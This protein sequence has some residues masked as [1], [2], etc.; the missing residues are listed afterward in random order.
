MLGHLEGT[1]VVVMSAKPSRLSF[2]LPAVEQACA[3]LLKEKAKEG[4]HFS[5]EFQSQHSC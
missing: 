3:L 1:V 5:E 2:L 4:G